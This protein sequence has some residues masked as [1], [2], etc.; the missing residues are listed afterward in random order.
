MLQH[1]KWLAGLQFDRLFLDSTKNDTKI[2]FPSVYLARI[3]NF[4]LTQL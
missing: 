2:A 3:P 1:H 4:I